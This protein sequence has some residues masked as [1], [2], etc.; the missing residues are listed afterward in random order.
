MEAIIIN[1]KRGR[2]TQTP[3]QMII[4]VP[5]YDKKKSESLVGKKVVYTCEGKD[6]KEITGEIRST[7]GNSGELRVLFERGMPGQA[8]GQR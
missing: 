2:K 8:I 7:H 5:K 6:K 1:F 3:N 4:V